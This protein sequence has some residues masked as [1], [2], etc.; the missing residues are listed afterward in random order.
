MREI[1][2]HRTNPSNEGIVIKA[3][4]EPGAGGANHRYLVSKSNGTTLIQF[5]FQ[6]GPIGESGVNGVTQEVLL[7]IVIDRLRSFQSGPY[8]CRDNALALEKLEDAMNFLHK[9]TK[10]RQRRGV[11]GTNTI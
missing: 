9:R 3:I 8:N 10:D 11:E 4:D 2:D 6:N 1:S 5:N 7:A